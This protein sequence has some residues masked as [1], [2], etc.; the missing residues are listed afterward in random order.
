[1]SEMVIVPVQMEA[2]E[3]W[4]NVLGSAWEDW[5]WWQKIEYSEGSDWD[6]VGEITVSITDP[7]DEEE[8][9]VI[10]KTLGVQDLANA[11]AELVSKNYGGTNL[12]IHDL[13]AVYGDCVLQ[14][15]VLGDVV[16]G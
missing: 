14:Q 13:D 2:E 10:T 4:S 7:N 16:Y 15:A 5:D 9:Q 11:Y 3:V 8:E 12:N 1:M 6:K